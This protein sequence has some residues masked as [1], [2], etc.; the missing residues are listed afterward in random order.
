MATAQTP[1][2][3]EKYDM[4]NLKKLVNITHEDVASVWG[5]TDKGIK[6]EDTDIKTQTMA[7]RR[8]CREAIK[9]GAKREVSYKY[10][11]KLQSKGRLY[12]D[13]PSLQNIKKSFRGLL[14]HSTAIDFDAINC[15]PRLLLN[16]CMKNN[17]SCNELASYCNQ[18]ADH[19]REFCE[20]D[21]LT[22]AEAKALFLSSFNK[23]TKITK[24]DGRANIK[25]QRFLRYDTEMKAIQSRL[26]KLYPEEYTNVRRSES[27]NIG[28]KFTSR[29]LNIEE[30]NMLKS[31]CDAIQDRY[32]T[33]TLC[34]DGM[35]LER[36]D[37]NGSY[38]NEETVIEH[39]NKAT[40]DWGIQW[41]VKE[42]DLSLQEFADNLNKQTNVMLYANTET[43]LCQNIFEYFF[44]NKFYKRDGVLYLLY[45]NQ[46]LTSHNTIVDY[47]TRTVTNCYGYVERV[48]KDD[49][50]T[51]QLLTK[52]MNGA[53]QITKMI[54]TLVPE[55]KRFMNDAEKRCSYHISFENGYWDYKKNRFILY[56]EDP[57]YD[58]INKIERDFTYM[59]VGHQKREALFDRV[60]Y[61]MF[62]CSP[63]NPENPDYRAMED[64]LHE[65]GIVFAGIISQKRWY[66]I[67]GERDSCKGVYDLLMRNAFGAYV[68]SFNSSSFA[69]DTKNQDPELQQK[70]LLKN[71]HARIATAQ[72][73]PSC[74]LDGNLI[75]KVSSGGDTID[76]R[77]LFKN[78]ETFQN[79]CK[80]MWLLNDEPRIKP[81]DTVKTRWGY[82][83]KSQFVDDPETVFKMKGIKYYKKDDDI[84][85]V[86]CND[87]EILNAFCSVL[88]DYYNRTDTAFPKELRDND[89]GN[90]DPVS[91]AH[92]LFNFG[93][94]DSIIP[95]NELKQIYTNN[96]DSFD[97]FSHMKR[98]LKQLGA[99]EYKV[100]SIRGLRGVALKMEDE[101]IEEGEEL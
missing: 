38:I 92:R 67:R 72:E 53:S 73:A 45:K 99:D 22:P 44:E 66:N 89:D 70:F 61:K 84:K 36:Y 48:S 16:V 101:D 91:E 71:R 94:H 78:T 23:D 43:D 35:L 18:R 88:F 54:L 97:N 49:T 26:M 81:V 27:D 60:F 7:I 28:G 9:K 63:D 65:M 62:A 86:F 98:I 79:V 10:S 56:E 47:V 25:N 21:N 41:D 37:K 5:K 59:P 90:Q 83:M 82:H 34:F 15:H 74:W 68:G 42:P 46:W 6:G 14:C 11:K 87:P 3:V 30:G 31:A 33:M 69:L 57:D 77:N 2:Y 51:Q 1:T 100:K 93:E 19:I 80:Y 64:F 96:K 17:I 55:N 8:L 50:I 20:V 12:C 39:L 76:A 75:K 13:C 95:N 40:E 4:N 24:K 58:T 52:T 29:I 85:D 32:T